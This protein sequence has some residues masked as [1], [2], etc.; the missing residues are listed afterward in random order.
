MNLNDK[1]FIGFQYLVP[2]HQ[3]SRLVGWFA[4]CKWQWLKNPLINWFVKQYDVDMS[5]AQE[6]DPTRYENFNAFFTRALKPE[7]RPITDDAKQI[8]CPA[9][10]AVSQLGKIEHQQVFQAKGHSFNVS[11]LLGGDPE[12]AY[13]FTN[14][15]FATIYLSPKD[16]HRLHMPVTGTLKEMIYV[17]GDLFSVNQTTAENVPNLFA[18]NERLVAIFDTEQGP[19][20][21]VLV[22]AMIVASIE[23]VWAGQVAPPARNLKATRY[24]KVEKVTIEKGEEMGRFKL[25]ST[26]VLL[27]PENTIEW[28]KA[29]GAGTPTMMGE[30]IAKIL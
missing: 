15:E 6:E 4:E 19:M 23:T 26:V 11:E 21:M 10:G 22:G 27:F 3:L 1:L 16:Y 18:R 28:N 9:D 25:G 5:L 20:A 29:L 2:Q 7:A 17:P 14:G 24:D 13:P 30:A 12:R 8:A